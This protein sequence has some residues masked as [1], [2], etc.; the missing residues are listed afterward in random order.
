[1]NYNIPMTFRKKLL[2]F[3]PVI[4]GVVIIMTSF[5]EN[6]VQKRNGIHQIEQIIKNRYKWAAAT[7]GVAVL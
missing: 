5:E 4:L 6:P 3:I 7:K 1:M 2:I